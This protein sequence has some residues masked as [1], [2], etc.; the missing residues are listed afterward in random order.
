VLN[1]VILASVLFLAGLAS[2]IKSLLM[3][4]MLVV[5]ALLILF[6]GLYSVFIL[7]IE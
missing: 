1:T 7:P 2:Q 5:F 6:W 3:R 4:S